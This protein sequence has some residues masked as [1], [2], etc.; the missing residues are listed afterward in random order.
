[1]GSRFKQLI[2]ITSVCSYLDLELLANPSSPVKVMNSDEG[3]QEIENMVSTPSNSNT[4]PMKKIWHVPVMTPEKKIVHVPLMTPD[5]RPVELSE[6]PFNLKG[7]HIL[8]ARIKR[9]LDAENEYITS[10]TMTTPIKGTPIKQLP[11]SPSQVNKIKIKIIWL[12]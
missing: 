8:G 7:D 10:D 3:F 12:F 5:R 1:M 9:D 6:L 11:F 4:T 2:S